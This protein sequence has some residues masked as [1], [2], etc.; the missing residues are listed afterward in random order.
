[1]NWLCCVVGHKR[2]DSHM[3]NEIVDGFAVSNWYDFCAR[4]DVCT[5]TGRRHV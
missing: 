3:H 2:K 1:M 5:P 4:C